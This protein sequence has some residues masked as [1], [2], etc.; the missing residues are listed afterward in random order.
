MWLNYVYNILF[1]NRELCKTDIAF[2]YC[3]YSV[4]FIK[5]VVFYSDDN[6]WHPL[7][8]YFKNFIIFSINIISDINFYLLFSLIQCFTCPCAFLFPFKHFYYLTLYAVNMCS[9]FYFHSCLFFPFSSFISFSFWFVNFFT[10]KI[11]NPLYLPSYFYHILE[12]FYQFTFCKIALIILFVSQFFKFIY[13]IWTTLCP[14][15]LLWRIKAPCLILKYLVFVVG[16]PEA[17]NKRKMSE[18]AHHRLSFFK[19]TTTR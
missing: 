7:Y 17:Q 16:T 11:I 2:I 5:K 1:C 12:I 8:D 10:I 4:I 9:K 6:K 19:S 18:S 3:Y 14:H 15:F 13:F